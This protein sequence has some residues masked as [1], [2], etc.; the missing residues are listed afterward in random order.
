LRDWRSLLMLIGQHAK[1]W[2]GIDRSMKCCH[3]NLI[4]TNP[5][6]LRFEI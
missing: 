5:R 2:I 1:K 4:K 3:N 6:G